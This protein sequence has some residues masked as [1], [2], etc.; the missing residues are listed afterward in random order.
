M[1]PITFRVPF[2]GKIVETRGE[3]GD[4]EIDVA[5]GGG[6]RDRLCGIEEL[7]LD[8]EPGIT[9]IT[10]VL[11]DEDR[12]RRGQAQHADLYLGRIIRP[13]DAASHQRQQQSERGAPQSPHS[14]SSVLYALRDGLIL[15]D[16]GAL[17]A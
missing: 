1:P 5:R 6:D 11:R 2:A 16:E 7:Q 15:P 8:V 12:R 4:T 13:R 17:P 3:R 14:V 10:L 9:K